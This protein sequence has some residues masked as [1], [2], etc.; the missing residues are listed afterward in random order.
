ML[1]HFLTYK[2]SLH[3]SLGAINIVAS[4]WSGTAGAANFVEPAV[5]ASSNGVLDILMIARP[6]PIPSISFTPPGGGSPIHPTGWVYEICKRPANP[7]GCPAGA[8]TVSD[9]GGVNKRPR[10]TPLPLGTSIA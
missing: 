3:R 4:V 2:T 9:Y 1:Y 6:K 5:F 10:L 7:T 8:G